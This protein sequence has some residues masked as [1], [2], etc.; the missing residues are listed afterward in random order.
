MEKNDQGCHGSCLKTRCT[1][2]VPT[3]SVLPILRMPSPLALNSNMRASTEGP[4]SYLS[5]LHEQGPR[6][7]FANDPTLKLGKHAQ[8]LKHRFGC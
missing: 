2:L 8:H 1:T 5:P 6:Y 3:P 7:S 4:T